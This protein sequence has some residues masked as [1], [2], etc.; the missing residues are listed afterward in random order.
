MMI[1]IPRNGFT[2]VELMI[3]IAVMAVMAGAVAMTV[4]T[5]GGGPSAGAA[6]FASR[7]AAAR[8]EAIVSGRPISAWVAASGYG[9][10]RFQ[11]GRWQP[12]SAAP[13]QNDNWQPDTVVVFSAGTETRG[14]IRFDNL[15]VPDSAASV[16]LSRDGQ[17]AEVRVAANGDV[18]VS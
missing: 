5:P 6:R 10:D 11:D 15:G 17:T 7:V 8:D 1:G 12:L 18:T 4:G 16:R 13:F 3:V 9:F 2:L 14:R